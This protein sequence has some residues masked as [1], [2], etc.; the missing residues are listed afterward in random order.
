VGLG[1]DRVE[2]QIKEMTRDDDWVARMT[3]C[4]FLEHCGQPAQGAAAEETRRRFWRSWDCFAVL[5]AILGTLQGHA[6][7]ALRAAVETKAAETASETRTGN[8]ADEW[9]LSA[10]E[11][12][13]APLLAA[14]AL[15]L[16]RAAAACEAAKGAASQVRAAWKKAGR[17]SSADGRRCGRMDPINLI[18]EELHIR[19]LLT[20]NY[21]FELER[22]LERLGFPEGELRP[23]DAARPG[24]A[25]QSQRILGERARSLVF[26]KETAADLT[27][28]AVH[29]QGYEYEI[30]HLHGWSGPARDDHLVITEPDYQRVY[31]RDDPEAHVMDEALSVVMGGNPIVFVGMGMREA[32]L[33]RP[34]RRFAATRQSNRAIFALLPAEDP[35]KARKDFAEKQYLQYGVHALFYGGAGV[36]PG[37]DAQP[38]SGDVDELRLDPWNDPA[39][40]VEQPGV[41]AGPPKETERER[42][43]PRTIARD[44]APLYRR[45]ERLRTLR[46]AVDDDEQV[47]RLAAWVERPS[48]AAFAEDLVASAEESDQIFRCAIAAAFATLRSPA[49]AR[50]RGAREAFSFFVE[51]LEGRIR[52]RALC[53]ALKQVSRERQDWW[54]RWRRVPEVRTYAQNLEEWRRKA[55]EGPHGWELN[56]RRAKLAFLQ[57][58]EGQRAPIRCMR[59]QCKSSDYTEDINITRMVRRIL[60]PQVQRDAGRRVLV[61]YGE[62][63]AGRGSLFQALAEKFAL[64]GGDDQS[65]DF[66]PF[67]WG[68]FTNAI[69]TTEYS[70]VVDGLIDFLRRCNLSEGNRQHALIRRWV[71]GR[72]EQRASRRDAVGSH[73]AEAMHRTNSDCPGRRGLIVLG[74]VEQLF[75]ST[76]VAK[77]VEV[78]EALSALFADEARN[79]PLDIVLTCNKARCQVVFGQAFGT[80][81]DNV[82]VGG[83]KFGRGEGPT[84]D[85]TFLPLENTGLTERIEAAVRKAD[86]LRKEQGLKKQDF[87]ELRADLLRELQGEPPTW[88]DALGGRFQASIVIHCAFETYHRSNGRCWD[89]GPLSLEAK[90]YEV[91]MKA[92]ARFIRGIG[93]AQSRRDEKQA[94]DVAISAVLGQYRRLERGHPHEKIKA[95]L[96]EAILKHLSIVSAPAEVVVLARCPQIREV[97]EQDLRV[98]RNDD[99]RIIEVVIE[100]IDWLRLR[101]LVFEVEK[102]NELQEETLRDSE[103]AGNAE[104]APIENEFRRFAVHQSMQ[105]YFFGRL[106]SPHRELGDSRLFT[107]SVLAS[108]PADLPAPTREGYKF[109]TNLICALGKYPNKGPV[110]GPTG[111]DKLERRRDICA[112]R[113]AV[114]LM[115]AALPLAVV[116]RC[117][118]FGAE[119]DEGRSS[120]GYFEEYRFIL[121]WMIWRGGELGDEETQDFWKEVG[122]LKE[123]LTSAWTETDADQ[124]LVRAVMDR[125]GSRRADELFARLKKRDR[126]N[127]LYQDEITWLYNECGLVS[128]AQGNLQ[129]AAA[130]FRAARLSNEHVEADSQNGPNSLRIQLNQTLV[131]IER[132]RFRRAE[133]ALSQ[134]DAQSERE[135][136]IAA[137]AHGYLGLAAH[138]RGRFDEARQFYD[139]ALSRLKQFSEDRATAIFNRH[140][141]DLLRIQGERGPAGDKL[142][143]ALAEAQMAR[144]RDL[145]CRVQMSMAQLELVNDPQTRDVTKILRRADDVMAYANLM[146]VHSL[147]ADALLIQGE[148]SELQG[149]TQAA[150]KRTVEALAL[151]Q[152]HGQR[153]RAMYAMWRLGRI[154]AARPNYAEQGKRLLVS[155]RRMADACDYQIVRRNADE[156]LM[157]R[158]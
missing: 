17:G 38:Q 157:S 130:L 140:L 63:G 86:F 7:N 23:D 55:T 28:F 114:S 81:V 84:F 46:R 150:G 147:K 47:G 3:W 127:A 117:S 99:K 5:T 42:T 97:A 83:V 32:D 71:A 137:I 54:R 146:D 115:R 133:Q 29:A 31:L 70:S 128:F 96:C 129:D 93:D 30:F 33:L 151:A 15:T 62:R 72:I 61:V 67:D 131:W 141:G 39:D 85:V 14:A 79:Y 78:V 119:V 10:E 155:A 126:F 74:G 59:Y 102:R 26:K 88:Q 27:D 80:R 116:S 13:L 2:T 144:Q 158:S 89:G 4:G 139:D 35:R 49:L 156:E 108:Q 21:D 123:S 9:R 142:R 107:V 52:T 113:A 135:P 153:L 154:V 103:R 149:D 92:I 105:S 124:A 122:I 143:M 64:P 152:L 37:D 121:F 109:L 22:G 73:L 68:L 11:R 104:Q 1:Q 58:G 18:L 66:T 56:N 24:C 20:T 36:R 91:G 69:F 145:V 118:E 41:A 8:P 110:I 75:R 44:E 12:F 45:L 136:V 25:L 16:G 87:A 40:A 138:I 134:I 101:H 111:R 112:L 100:H 148:V 94:P 82:R 57:R 125:L 106:G 76:G 120:V 132:G 43:A 50:S 77:N 51:E 48:A 98:K 95:S 65:V 53:A 34:L 60:L 90:E 6:M 19:R